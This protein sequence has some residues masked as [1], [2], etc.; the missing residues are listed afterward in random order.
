M[1]MSHYAEGQGFGAWVY[2]LTFA[3]LP[4]VMLVSFVPILG[5]DT[6]GG[7]AALAALALLPVL[8]LGNMLY[9][10]TE[11]TDGVLFTRFGLVVPW[12]WKRIPVS[13]MRGIR[14]VTYRPLRDA[15]GWGVRMGR[16][17]GARC[18]YHNARGN[19][20]V[21]FETEE[22]RY[23]IGTQQPEALEMALLEA[24]REQGGA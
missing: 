8:V 2:V 10:R 23:I 5:A 4:G 3:L 1:V 20:G 9:L 21:F 7:V 6:L 19:R 14:R 11:V 18:W 16:F 12:Y 22:R 13:A 17:E 24:Q 15:G